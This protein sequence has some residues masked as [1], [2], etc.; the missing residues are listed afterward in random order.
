MKKYGI[1]SL[2]TDTIYIFTIVK[3]G[4]FG[5]FGTC[6]LTRRMFVRN[7]AAYV[8]TSTSNIMTSLFGLV[9]YKIKRKFT[10]L[11]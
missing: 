9:E 8:L 2:V 5:N 11:G 6:I 4:D 1:F 10:F 3:Q 7:N